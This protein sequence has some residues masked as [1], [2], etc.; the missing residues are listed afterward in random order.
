MKIEKSYKVF[1]ISSFIIFSVFLFS[2]FIANQFKVSYAAGVVDRSGIPTRTFTTNI[3]SNSKTNYIKDSL[4][5]N[6]QSSTFINNFDIPTNLRTSDNSTP[7]YLLMKNLDVP[8]TTEQIELI[9]NNPATISDKG[10]LYILSHGYNINND[11]SSLFAEGA[12]GAV[13]DNSYKQYVT[14]IALW[15]YI[16]E[17]KGTFASTYCANSGCDFYENELTNLKTPEQIRSLINTASNNNGFQFLKYIIPLVDNAKGYSGGQESAISSLSGTK[18]TYQVNND[19]TLLVTESVNPVPSSNEGNYMY[20]SLSVQDPNNYGVYIVDG[21]NNK[22]TNL[23]NL[24]GSF[25]VVVPLKEDITTMDLSSI[26]I[27][28]FGHFVRDDGYD[29]RVT[30][31]GDSLLNPGKTQKYS[32]LTLAYTPSEVV[33]TSFNLYN[34]VKISKVDATNSSEIPG[35]TLVVKDKNN[36]DNTWTW[37]S[38][39]QPHYIYLPDGTYSL[40]ET[41]APTGYELSTECIDFTVDGNKILAV[42]MKNEPTVPIPNTSLFK[43]KI[44]YY[45]GALILSIG[46]AIVVIS[47]MKKKNKAN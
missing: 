17:N 3:T 7:L 47:F 21:S 26:E 44:L 28:V 10:I 30:S 11:Y 20:Y 31:A 15:L 6:G 37:V 46:C 38:T 24:I 4:V 27:D 32:N 22:I 19:F 5:A 23:N 8:K 40:C 2:F 18:L 33:G 13:S 35:A 1:G 39:Y 34:F 9:D 45:L 29:Y 14:Q 16:Y 43:S 12:F 25:K 36:P 41:I 42:A